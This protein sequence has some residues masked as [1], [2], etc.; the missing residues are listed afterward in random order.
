MIDDRSADRTRALAVEAG[1]RVVAS[2]DVLADLAPT[3]GKGG[4]LWKGV[5]AATGDLLA[6]VDGD[7]SEFNSNFVVGLLG[8]L[9]PD[10]GG[11][12]FVKGFYERPLDGAPRGGGRVTELAARPILSILFDHLSDIIQPLAGEFAAPRSTLE[13]LPFIEGYGVDIG[14]LADAAATFG[15]GTIAQVDLG[16]RVHRNR[17]INE[18]GPMATEVL[19]AALSRA[20]IPFLAPSSST[21]L[22]EL[23]SSC[24]R[25]CH[26][27]SISSST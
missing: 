13:R 7:V 11:V 26:P 25:S 23:R 24:T 10:G 3:R 20:N 21:P 14:L 17:P 12:A 18:L 8:P 5:A 9:M 4:A 22:S 15:I 6:F 1:A 2:G 19:L 27:S 16:R